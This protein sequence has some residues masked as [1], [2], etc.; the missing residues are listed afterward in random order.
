MSESNINISTKLIPVTKWNEFYE[1]PPQGGMRHLIFN[2]KNNGFKDAFKRVGRRVL[3]DSQRF[4][5]IVEEQNKDK[6]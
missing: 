3:V 5:E 4:W 1:W 2:A 6:S